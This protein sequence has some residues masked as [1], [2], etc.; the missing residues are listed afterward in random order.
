MPTFEYVARDGDTGREILDS[1]VAVTQEEAITTLLLRNRLVVAIEVKGADRTRGLAGG[2]VNL[3]DL[4]SFTRQL[5]TMVDAGMPVISC[6]RSLARQSRSKVMSDIIRD[7][8]ERVEAGIGF[9]EALS[10]NPQ[11]FDTLYVCLVGAGE[12]SGMLAESLSRIAT[13]LENTAR[14][15][16]K[17]KS[18]I[19]Y[20]A[21]V[22]VV[23]LAVT[24]FLLA[25][26]VPVFGEIY[27]SFKGKLPAPTQWLIDVS[28]FIKTW[29]AFI[30]VAMGGAVFGWFSFI[31]TKS[32]REFWDARRIRLPIFGNIA[33]SICLA[34]F[35]RTFSSL[36]HGGVPIL[37]VLQTVGKA[38]GNVVMEKAVIQTTAAIENGSTIADALAKHPVFP[39][40]IVDMVSAGEQTGKL[41]EMLE[42]IANHL[43][44]EVE[45]SL[46][47]LTSII[48][49]VL[50]AFLGVVLGT[51]VICMFLP[52]FKLSE[53]VSGN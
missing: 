9:S 44:E 19:M 33:H 52:I 46:A 21:V 18:A 7:V 53:L 39:E 20:P 45:V 16:H 49:P 3:K 13:Y 22:S 26:V 14:L 8:A 31:K 23:A 30:L 5:A 47:G 29:L 36:V 27:D 15:R 25:R 43:D 50:I 51:I 40:L 17:V 1:I 32:G 24:I 11:A 12:K 42:R 10:K 35:A 38:S 37:N 41:D 28:N 34:R 2:R 4:V 48:E 6:L